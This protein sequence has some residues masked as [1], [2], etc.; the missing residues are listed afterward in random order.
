MALVVLSIGCSARLLVSV[1]SI[2][3][4]AAWARCLTTVNFLFNLEKLDMYFC[5]AEESFTYRA[6]VRRF[7]DDEHFCL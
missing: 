1:S 7:C 3:D 2:P 5:V 6:P 4:K